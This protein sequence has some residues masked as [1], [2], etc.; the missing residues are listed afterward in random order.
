VASRQFPG[1]AS[2]KTKRKYHIYNGFVYE[3]GLWPKQLRCHVPFTFALLYISIITQP[4][5]PPPPSLK[6]LQKRK[7]DLRHLQGTAYERR[8][9]GR[10]S[11]APKTLCPCL[12]RPFHEEVRVSTKTQFRRMIPLFFIQNC[13]TK[14]EAKPTTGQCGL[15]Y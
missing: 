11:Q 2:S 12:T 6:K 9:S 5:T 4:P 14:L 1:D 3:D 15:L 7:F 8:S 13:F 10:T